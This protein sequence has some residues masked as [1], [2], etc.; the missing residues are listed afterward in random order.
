M[1]HDALEVVR[2]QT[3]E[4]ATLLGL[5]PPDVVLG[6]TPDPTTIPLLMKRGRPVLLVSKPFLDLPAML[7]RA[8]LGHAVAGLALGQL[9][10]FQRVKL[11][12]F[13]G[14]LAVSVHR[15][16]PAGRRDRAQGCSPHGLGQAIASAENRLQLAAKQ[17]QQAELGTKSLINRI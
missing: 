3:A 4:V 6:R 13:P 14:T 7:R 12:I 11:A 9:R 1:P 8:A 2:S 5:P 10:S 17:R 15:A 16:E